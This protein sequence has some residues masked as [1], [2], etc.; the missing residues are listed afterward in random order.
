MLNSTGGVHTA[1]TGKYNPHKSNTGIGAT[2]MVALNNGVL[3]NLYHKVNVYASIAESL[4]STQGVIAS[5]NGYEIKN[6]VVDKFA[7]AQLPGDA[8]IATKTLNAKAG[9]YYNKDTQTYTGNLE[10]YAFVGEIK[11]SNITNCYSLS[12]RDGTTSVEAYKSKATALTFG[13]G[14][15][16]FGG[17]IDE[18]SNT[19]YTTLQA[20]T[21]AQDWNADYAAMYAAYEENKN[22]DTA[23][24]NIT[25]NGGTVAI[26]L[27]DDLA[28]INA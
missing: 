3:Q 13:E 19:V 28:G 11:G 20:G 2:G 8:T 6:C 21:T 24:W 12:K 14:S 7:Q 5:I 18:L 9:N 15:S 23:I 10:R 27:N 16:F 4:V 22:L 26:A 1:L 25:N 17:T